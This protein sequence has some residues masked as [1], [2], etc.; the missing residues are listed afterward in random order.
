MKSTLSQ[1]TDPTPCKQ[2]ISITIITIIVIIINTIII[3]VTMCQSDIVIYLES[4]A[5]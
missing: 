3:V 4:L 5:S 1:F 2:I